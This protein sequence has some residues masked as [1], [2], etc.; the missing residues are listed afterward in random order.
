MA[1]AVGFEP[2]TN[3]FGDHYSTVEPYP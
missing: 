1:G 2:T 3:G